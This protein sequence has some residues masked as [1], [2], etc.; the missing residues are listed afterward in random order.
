MRKL[1][2]SNFFRFNFEIIMKTGFLILFVSHFVKAYQKIEMFAGINPDTDYGFSIRMYPNMLAEFTII[3][4]NDFVCIEQNYCII[5]NI[6]KIMTFLGQSIVYYDAN[7]QLNLIKQPFK[8]PYQFRFIANDTSNIGSWLGIS[9][10]STYLKYLYAQDYASNYRVI[11]R[12]GWDNT[13]TYKTGVYEGDKILMAN[14]FPGSLFISNGTTQSF[15]NITVCLNNLLDMASPGLSLFG[16]PD[17]KID[18]WKSILQN[19]DPQISDSTKYFIKLNLTNHFGSPL[20]Q[21]FFNFSEFS[22]NNTFRVKSFSPLFDEN[23]GCDLYIGS[24]SLK[25]YNFKFYYIE[26]DAGYDVSFSLDGFV[27]PPPPPLPVSSHTILKIFFV[28]LIVGV[29]GLLVWKVLC[30]GHNPAAETPNSA[31]NIAREPFIELQ[32]KR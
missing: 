18:Y 17:N 4:S 27:S 13:L 24:L 5:Q 2:I 30:T 19:S 25:K 10:N 7:V 11:F 16:V 29:V 12:L 21:M 3:S 32:N 20:G 6:K 8:A 31:T 22:V 26:Y 1:K 28:I 9:P 14:S 23:R 15:D